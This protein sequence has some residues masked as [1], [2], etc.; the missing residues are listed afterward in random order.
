MHL[1]ESPGGPG[2]PTA[3]GGDEGISTADRSSQHKPGP[4]GLADIGLMFEARDSTLL[5][6]VNDLKDVLNI[7]ISPKEGLTAEQVTDSRMKYG[8]NVSNCDRSCI[9]TLSL[10]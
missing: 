4:I 2:E 8:D 3:S 5:A 1:D 9:S 6:G 10:I 7:P